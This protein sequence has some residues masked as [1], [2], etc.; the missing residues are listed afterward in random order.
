MPDKRGG[1]AG[2]SQYQEQHM[3]HTLLA[4]RM[5]ADGRCHRCWRVRPSIGNGGVEGTQF[6]MNIFTFSSLQPGAGTVDS[7]VRW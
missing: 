4:R 5:D 6:F 7:A 1:G 3:G 2:S